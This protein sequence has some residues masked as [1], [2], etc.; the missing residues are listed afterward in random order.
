MEGIDGWSIFFKEDDDLVAPFSLDEIK[1]VVFSCD[2]NK[3]SG[4]DGFSMT[5]FKEN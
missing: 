5:F 3:F 2:G 1:K 4:A